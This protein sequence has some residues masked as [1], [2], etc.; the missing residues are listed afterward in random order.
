MK[1]RL[2][3]PPI[4]FFLLCSVVLSTIDARGAGVKKR[5]L[6]DLV[7]LSDLILVGDIVRVTDGLDGNI[8]YTEITLKVSSAIKGEVGGSYT[9]RQF[10]LLNPRDMGNGY[11]NL[12]VTPDG[13]PR[14]SEGQKVMLFLYKAAEITGLRTTV[15]LF[16]GKFDIVDGRISN[17]IDNQG[18]FENLAVDPRSLTEQDRK[19]LQVKKGPIREESFTSFV[20]KA[21]QQK[22]FIQE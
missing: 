4:L 12:N 22:W 18:L 21:V 16:Q 14:Y 19:L 1:H 15:G 2:K 10:G 6:A 3:I 9:F 17:F 13:W 11:T 7:S 5:N 20:R 8:P